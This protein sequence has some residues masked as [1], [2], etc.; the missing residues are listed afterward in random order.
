MTAF[1]H[2]FQPL[3]IGGCTI[4][5]RI[6]ST[7]HDTTLPTEAAVNDALIAY[8]EAR[9]RGGVGLIILQVAGVHETARYT[10]HILMASDDS[11]I[12]GYRRL[13]ER[14]HSYG[15]KVF[16][17]LFHP[18]REILESHGGLL[19][20]AYAPSAIPNERFHVMPRA[21][22]PQ[23]MAEI[24]S[25]YGDAARRMQVAG[26][27]GCEVV[28]S[29]GYLPSQFLNPRV[30]HRTDGYGGDLSSRLRF[31]HE[32]IADIRA[33]T[34]GK[35]VV[36]MRISGGEMDHEGLTPDESL[37]AIASLE[38]SIDYVSVVGGTSASVGGAIHIVPPMS[39][40]TGYMAP[41]TARVKARVKIP[42]FLAGRINQ[43]QVAEA[44]IA[45]GQADVCGMTRALIADPEMPN[46]ARE[47]RAEDIR[48]CIACNQA[49]IGHFHKGQP[50]S[51]IQHP[52]TGRELRFGKLDPASK[53]KRVMV[54]GGGPAGM[55]AAVIAAQR[56]HRVTLYE[57]SGRL[58]GQALLAQLLPDRAEFGGLV[59]NLARELELAQV[60][61]RKNIKVDRA[62][63]DREKPDVVVL[64]TGARP[65]TPDFAR[66]G[67]LKVVDAWE[68][69][70]GKA[71]VGNSVVVI[72]WRCDWTGI[73]MAVRFARSG[74]R[75]HLASNGTMPGESIPLYVRDQSNAQLQELGVTVLPYTR[76]FGCDDRTVYLQQTVSGKPIEIDGVDTLVLCT[77]H[78]A[79][80]ELSDALMDYGGELRIVGDSLAPRT[81]EEAIFEGFEVGASL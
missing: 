3:A 65:F 48:A 63:I 6:L 15:T 59:T 38:P 71:E 81:A 11:A 41:F 33:K 44:L 39:F 57:A 9:A 50:I 69:L 47:G 17:Q 51:C 37:E 35:F 53:P 73:G 68:V 52:A 4:K 28:A 72:D 42:V 23:L 27:D 62:L 49:C 22:S 70:T 43:P 1:T 25:G 58:G 77:G 10:N 19:A 2:L 29:H 14:V 34:D 60:D 79:E 12:E 7:G 45:S 8:Q 56:G 31:L 78:I 30:N 13:A 16:G 76:L 61:V 80:T 55:K 24:I 32:V 40:A 18:G 21:L 66:E 20:V 46:K 36:G 26:L 74:C 67:T 64:A 5:N 75:V 54:V